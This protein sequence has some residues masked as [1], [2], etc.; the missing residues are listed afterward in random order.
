MWGNYYLSAQNEYVGLTHTA[1]YDENKELGK[2]LEY[3]KTSLM[4][5]EYYDS[6]TAAIDAFMNDKNVALV[7]DEVK[8]QQLRQ[9]YASQHEE[10]F[11]VRFN[12]QDL[13]K[14][15]S[16]VNAY[17][18]VGV[19]VKKDLLKNNVDIVASFLQTIRQSIKTYNGSKESLRKCLDNIDL[20]ILGYDKDFVIECYDAM[21]LNFIP[22]S[23]CINEI[24]KFS[25]LHDISLSE[26]S[27]VK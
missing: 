23:Q 22:A 15:A 11:V 25:E 5:L 24:N 6:S 8:M 18:L 3:C 16:G 14:Q 20:T 7:V 27:F 9:N 4:G 19:F 12:V 10:S 21:G 1:A 26:K 2:T 17:P 13:Y